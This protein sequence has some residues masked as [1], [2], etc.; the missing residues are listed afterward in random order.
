MKSILFPS[1]DVGRILLKVFFQFFIPKK[2]E[3]FSILLCN[4]TFVYFSTEFTQNT[5]KQNLLGLC[6]NLYD[7]GIL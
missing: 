5:L 1:Y 6:K 4:A 7:K 2:P 3:F